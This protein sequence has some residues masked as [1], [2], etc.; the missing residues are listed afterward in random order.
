MLLLTLPRVAGAMH[1][2]LIRVAA[3]ALV[4][5]A[6]LSAETAALRVGMDLSYPPFET[7]GPDGQPSGIS[8]ELA[9]ALGAGLGRSV[10][11][12]NMPFTGLIPAL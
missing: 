9:R 6:P 2:M 10:E 5:A 11:I 4:L 8:V 12:E 1:G 3:L 7:I